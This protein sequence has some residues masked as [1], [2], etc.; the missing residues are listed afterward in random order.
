MTLSVTIP[1]YNE[2]EKRLDCLGTD[3]TGNDKGVEIR[4]HFSGGWWIFPGNRWRADIW[5]YS[6]SKI[7][8]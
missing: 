6:N 1:V 4:R 5:S 7:P 3:L 8:E 2:E